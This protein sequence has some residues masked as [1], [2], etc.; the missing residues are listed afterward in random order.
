MCN[1][2]P[3]THTQAEPRHATEAI[4]AES[5][6][7]LKM[8]GFGD[9]PPAGHQGNQDDQ[10]N[11]APSISSPSPLFL[12]VSYTGAHA[13]LQPMPE[14]ARLCDELTL[15]DGS[16][17]FPH[18]WYTCIYTHLYYSNTHTHT[19]ILSL[20]HTLCMYVFDGK[21]R[22]S[23]TWSILEILLNYLGLL[24]IILFVSFF[25]FFFCILYFVF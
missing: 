16:P 23:Y 18:L 21:H 6:A 19:H 14:H 17:R 13:P 10:D 12:Y 7:Y 5:I 11:E 20:T 9:K 2:P 1:P 15:N 8:F 24:C 4:T 3:H 22:Y 25:L